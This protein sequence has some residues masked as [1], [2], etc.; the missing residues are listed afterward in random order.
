MW[1]RFAVLAAVAGLIVGCGGD[2]TGPNG[3]NNDAN[4]S[5]NW[6]MSA[7]NMSGGG[8]SCN[9]GPTPLTLTQSGKSF[10]GTYGLTNLSCQGPGGSAGGQVT[11]GTIVNGTVNGSTVTFDLDTP[12]FHHTGTVTGNSMSG[13]ASWRVDFGAPT[14]VVTL[15]GSWAAAKQ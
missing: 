6:S 11:G 3:G 13:T 8:I 15:S 1:R 10:T 12:D 5:G 7:S 2:S 14:G 4:V 9:A